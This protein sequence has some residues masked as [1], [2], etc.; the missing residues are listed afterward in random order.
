MVNV[1]NMTVNVGGQLW[2]GQIG[3]GTLTLANGGSINASNWVVVARGGGAGVFNMT[4]GTFT[5]TYGGAN[6]FVIG[7]G[8]ETNCTR[9]AVRCLVG[10]AD[11]R[12]CE[13]GT[14]LY[15]A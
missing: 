6:N 3:N 11:L 15:N 8:N 9:A 7:N 2:V 10:G 12:I 13:T 4:G 14:G 1:S 5:I